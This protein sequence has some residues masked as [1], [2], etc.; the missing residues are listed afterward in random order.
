MPRFG[1]GIRLAAGVLRAAAA[2]H[3]LF[4]L[5]DVLRNLV[6]EDLEV[7]AAKIGDRCAVARGIDVDANVVGFGAEGGARRLILCAGCGADRRGQ[8]R[9]R[10]N[11]PR[12]RA[13]CGLP[14]PCIMAL[15][16]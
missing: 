3:D 6:L 10:R 2:N 1:D 13:T 4:E 8:Q 14:H 16:R 15:G 5:L 11:H 7:L 9:H 12:E